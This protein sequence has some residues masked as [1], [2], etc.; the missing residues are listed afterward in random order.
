MSRDRYRDI[1]SILHF[2][3]NMGPQQNDR[4][5]K[6][7]PFFSMVQKRAMKFFRPFQELF[8]DESLVL[9]RGKLA[10]IQY[11]LSKR[12]RFGIKFFMI[13]DCKTGYI[14]DS[15][16]YSG[17]DVDIK[18]KDPQGFSGAVV[19]TLMDKFFNRKHVLYTDNYYISPALSKFLLEEETGSCGTVRANRRN[20]PTF[21]A[22]ISRGTCMKKKCENMLA[23]QWHDKRMVNILTTVDKFEMQETDKVGPNTNQP[24]LKSDPVVDYNKNMRLIDKS[25]MMISSIDCLRKTVK[26]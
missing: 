7:R 21:P 25:D 13:C 19:K 26:W 20:W 2:A 18:G 17:S 24:V 15:A 22:A 16:I 8:V 5:W 9:F 14:L 3:L 6:I 10:F 1:L 12:H 11:V 23:I 4:L